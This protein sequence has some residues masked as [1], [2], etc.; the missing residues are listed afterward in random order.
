[1]DRSKRQNDHLSTADHQSFDMKDESMKTY[2]FHQTDVSLPRF[3][4]IDPTGYSFSRKF[5]GL[6]DRDAIELMMNGIPECVESLLP[7]KTYV[8]SNRKAFNYSSNNFAYPFSPLS[9]SDVYRRDV[10]LGMIVCSLE[11]GH[12]PRVLLDLCKR[13]GR[14]YHSDHM[15]R[16]IKNWKRYMELKSMV[17]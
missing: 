16:A 4:I 11:G 8:D 6:E 3:L 7:G 1:M 10:F 5:S 14:Q 15:I 2:S 13:Y 9:S 17:I 12:D